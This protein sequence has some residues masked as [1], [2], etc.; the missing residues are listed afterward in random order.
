M[1]E[2]K[3]DIYFEFNYSRLNLAAF[4]KTS[5]KLEYYKEQ[6]YKSYFDNYKEL[7][8]EKLEK[9]LE[10]NIL[11]IEKSTGEFVR[12]IYLIVETPQSISIKLSVTKNNEGNKII[13]EDAMYLVQDAKQQLMKSNQDLGIIH[14]IVENY[15][16]DDVK[17]KFLPLEKK[18][19][20]FSIDIIFICFP[21]DL[22]K[23]FERLFLKQQ[24]YI[25]QFVCSNYIKTFNFT[26]K[27]QNI[28]ECAKDIVQ[29]ANKQEV[30]SIPKE[31]KKKGF[32]EKLF[33]F[34]K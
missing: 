3:F 19:T 33:H 9:F 1:S 7:N 16:L 5:D 15:V 30:V 29:G 20:K 32:F 2:R 4:S 23:S 27:E 13:K 22:L 11:A 28:C 8:F 34:F 21:K 14:I 12:D 6:T 17:Y 24:I 26:N 31:L 18:C 10:E 25:N